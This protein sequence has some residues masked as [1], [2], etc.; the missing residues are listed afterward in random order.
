VQEEETHYF[1]I[2]GQN[3]L[4]GLYAE[5]KIYCDGY[6][7]GI[8]DYS[9]T[10]YPNGLM[11][12]S[13]VF[14]N[15]R[16][17]IETEKISSLIRKF[18]DE[19]GNFLEQKT[20]YQYIIQDG[21]INLVSE[22]TVSSDN[23]NVSKHMLYP[24]HDLSMLTQEQKA[25]VERMIEL[26]RLT[27]PLVEKQMVGNEQITLVNQYKDW[28]NNLILPEKLYTKKGNGIEEVRIIY[29]NYDLYG[30]PQY[31]TKD[32]AEKVVYLWG[33]NHRYPVAEIKN[34]TY[35]QVVAQIQG[36]QTTIN[37]IAAGNTFSNSDQNKINALRTALPNAQVTT[38]TYKPLVGI[39]TVTDPNGITTH[40]EYDSFTRL[41]R[42]YLIE[43]G[44]EKTIQRYN[45]HYQN[46]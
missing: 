23:K 26:N 20:D 29:H 7:D 34:A 27:T 12:T 43:N 37:A 24:L 11:S 13:F 3:E 16:I 6:A 32:D 31:I 1:K 41:K 9:P 10:F 35:T 15:Y 25:P 22:T 21:C 14:S 38:Y 17:K 28:G 39:L 42:T 8:Y 18:F 36:G 46:Q 5:R 2:T 30:N 44:S 19:N 40:Y 4:T 45:Y 33:Y